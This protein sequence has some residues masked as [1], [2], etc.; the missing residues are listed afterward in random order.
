MARTQIVAITFRVQIKQICARV[1]N[2]FSSASCK[3]CKMSWHCDGIA[4]FCVRLDDNRDKLFST[5]NRGRLHS[6]CSFAIVHRIC[7]LI[8]ANFPVICSIGKVTTNGAK[9]RPLSSHVTSS[10]ADTL[11]PHQ[12]ISVAGIIPFAMETET[13]TAKALK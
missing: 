5:V 10:G 2:A 13:K 9:M 4:V 6:F 12:M 3:L 11:F 1:D 7:S 8:Y